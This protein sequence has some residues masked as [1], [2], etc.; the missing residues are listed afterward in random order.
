MNNIR[1]ILQIKWFN[2]LIK[3][4]IKI[5]NNLHCKINSFKLTINFKKLINLRILNVLI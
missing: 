2:K 4:N 5:T 1:I 3:I